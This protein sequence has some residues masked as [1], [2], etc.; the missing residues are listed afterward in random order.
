MYVHQKQA[1]YFLKEREKETI[2]PNDSDTIDSSFAT[3]LWRKKVQSGKLVYHN[4]LSNS[5]S[6]KKPSCFKGGILADEVSL[7]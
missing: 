7:T 2:I 1:L 4:I 6:F 5:D 3:C